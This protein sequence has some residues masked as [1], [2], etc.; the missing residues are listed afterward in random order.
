MQF[1]FLKCWHGSFKN[2][3]L[4]PRNIV[5]H[6]PIFLSKPNTVN[7]YNVL[8]PSFYYLC[9]FWVCQSIDFS[10]VW[11][12]RIIYSKK[13]HTSGNNCNPRNRKKI[14]RKK[15]KERERLEGKNKERRRK[16]K[17]YSNYFQRKLRRSL[18]NNTIIGWYDRLLLF[19][20]KYIP[21]F[22][23]MASTL[24]LYFLSSF[25]VSCDI[26]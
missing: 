1:S 17:E 13:Y 19:L 12:E 18:I 24:V 25:T 10:P 11:S 3:F 4:L 15:E 22:F 26:W 5:N 9:H 6:S 2:V 21:S 14:E 20:P 8:V 16:N 7:R 23:L